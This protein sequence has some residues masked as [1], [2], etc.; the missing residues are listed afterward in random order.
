M[1]EGL[2]SKFSLHDNKTL[3]PSNLSPYLDQ[4]TMISIRNV[5][6]ETS[7]LSQ[8]QQIWTLRAEKIKLETK[9]EKLKKE[10]EN[11]KRYLSELEKERV[12][13]E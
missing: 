6:D 10:L 12:P 5:Q 9:Y 11:K 13:P 1:F 4:N 8:K 7:A 2:K 3:N